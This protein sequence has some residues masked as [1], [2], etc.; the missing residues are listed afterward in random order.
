MCREPEKY[1]YRLGTAAEVRKL[2]LTADKTPSLL[3]QPKTPRPQFKKLSKADRAQVKGALKNTSK[4]ETQQELLR[5]QFLVEREQHERQVE[6][7]TTKLDRL[8]SMLHKQQSNNGMSK[9]ERLM[10]KANQHY[11][12]AKAAYDFADYKTALKHYLLAKGNYKQLQQKYNGDEGSEKFAKRLAKI[13]GKIEEI[14]EKIQQTI[15][16]LNSQSS[17][18]PFFAPPPPQLQQSQSQQDNSNSTKTAFD[19]FSFQPNP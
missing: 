1:G 4:L 18:L 10:E 11:S 15:Q 7:L 14:R 16:P 17:Q 12:E 5:K 13:K 19:N 2:K 6:Q 9:K 3:L 8:E